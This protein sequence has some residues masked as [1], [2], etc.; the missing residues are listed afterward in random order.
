LNLVMQLHVLLQVF[1]VQFFEFLKHQIIV[2]FLQDLP[3]FLQSSYVL[4]ILRLEGIYFEFQLFGFWQSIHDLNWQN[5]FL[6]F[7][8]KAFDERS[9]SF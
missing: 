6:K 4:L 8:V 5:L 2:F 1:F 7:L 3:N 9:L